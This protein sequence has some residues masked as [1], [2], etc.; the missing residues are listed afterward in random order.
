MSALPNIYAERTLEFVSKQVT[1]SNHIEFY[2]NWSTKLLTIHADK[3]N[4]FR[5]QSLLLTQDAL[6]RKYDA[7]SKVCDFNKYTLKVLIGMADAKEVAANGNE[8]S[9]DG[10]GSDDDVDMDSDSDEDNLMLIRGTNS[11]DDDGDDNENHQDD[12][13]EMSGDSH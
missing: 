9:N 5:H 1:A 6:T 3:E 4:V 11:D 13:E 12:D 8:K 10:D 2:L 7:L